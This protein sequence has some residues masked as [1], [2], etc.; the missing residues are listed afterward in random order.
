MMKTQEPLGTAPPITPTVA[1]PHP[2]EGHQKIPL[3]SGL[4]YKRDN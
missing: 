3:P 2:L 4:S 1:L